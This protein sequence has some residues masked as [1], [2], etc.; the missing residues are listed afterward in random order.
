M[1]HEKI[2]LILDRI[3]LTQPLIDLDLLH[4]VTLLN[5]DEKLEFNLDIYCEILLRL[6]ACVVVISHSKDNRTIDIYKSEF[7]N[8]SKKIS[9]SNILTVSKEFDIY[10]ER[11][12]FYMRDFEN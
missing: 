5:W 2:H 9:R 8:I 7:E 11:F 3:K 4:E 10:Y 12:R 1:K 6:N